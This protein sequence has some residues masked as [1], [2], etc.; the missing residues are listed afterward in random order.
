MSKRSK[1]QPDRWQPGPGA[2]L[3]LLA[4]KLSL[5]ITPRW[6]VARGRLLGALDA[7]GEGRLTLL[8][9]PAGSGK[10]VLVSSW[11][12]T[13]VPGPVAW[14]SL[15]AADNDPARFWFYLLAA[16]RQSGVAAPGSRLGSLA[17][18][19]GG[20]DRGW[21]LELAAALAELAGPVVVILDDFQALT[22][23]AV[24]DSLATVLRRSS[25]SLRLGVGSRGGAAGPL[26]R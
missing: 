6:L 25:A 23:P 9:G 18:P 20:P 21:V 12:T 16:L 5:P 13:T 26:G 1:G 7:G 4:S 19:I 2:G 24:L 15:D 3:P 22:N 11:A 14:L 8:T 10:T 17:G